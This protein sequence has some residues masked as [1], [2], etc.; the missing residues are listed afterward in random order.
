M[1]LHST[2]KLHIIQ[3]PLDK[4]HEKSLFLARIYTCNFIKGK[5]RKRNEINK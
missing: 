4:Q 1:K 3:K 2:Y 5:P